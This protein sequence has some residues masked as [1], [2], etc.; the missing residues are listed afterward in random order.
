VNCDFALIDG[1]RY[2][3]NILTQIEYFAISKAD[4]LAPSVA[5]ASIV[6][7]VKRDAAMLRYHKKYPQY[8]F[9]LHKGYGTKLHYKMLRKHGSS[10]IHRKSFRLG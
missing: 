3:K 2:P 6:A 8:R 5:A 1:T 7:K 10:P 9:D 4:N